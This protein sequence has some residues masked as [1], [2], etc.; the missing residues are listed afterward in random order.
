MINEARGIIKPRYRTRAYLKCLTE[1]CS[2][3][4][5]RIDSTYINLSFDPT[6]WEKHREMY[7]YDSPKPSWLRSS[8]FGYI[9]PQSGDE[10]RKAWMA[11]DLRWLASESWFGADYLI[12]HYLTRRIITATYV[13]QT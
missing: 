9:K 4:S 12:D 13:S 8:Q 2:N 5:P 1:A 11:R 3:L 7:L 10:E 6:E